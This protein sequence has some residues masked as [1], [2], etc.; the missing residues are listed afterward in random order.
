MISPTICFHR[1]AVSVVINVRTKTIAEIVKMIRGKKSKKF[2]I[3]SFVIVRDGQSCHYR[4]HINLRR[5]NSIF[6]N[7]KY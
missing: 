3:L 6:K 7:Y 4:Q 1:K 5:R 2:L